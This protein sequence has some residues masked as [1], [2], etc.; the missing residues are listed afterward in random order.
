[1][2]RIVLYCRLLLQQTAEAF[3]VYTILAEHGDGSG[4]AL[5]G[6][7]IKVVPSCTCHSSHLVAPPRPALPEIRA[8]RQPPCSK[9]S[10]ITIITTNNQPSTSFPG[11]RK[12]LNS[13][14]NG[15]NLL[16]RQFPSKVCLE[17]DKLHNKSHTCPTSFS[18]KRMDQNSSHK[19][20]DLST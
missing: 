1:M 6:Q 3:H 20:G 12:E 10:Q 15:H 4:V 7:L 5:G 19:T 16:P 18:W 2:T 14:T 17:C 11:E 9:E 13:K 8:E